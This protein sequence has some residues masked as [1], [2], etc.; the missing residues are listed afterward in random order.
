ERFVTDQLPLV[1][2][3]NSAE[4][5]E[6]YFKDK[7]SFTLEIP[8][9][10]PLKNA[11][12]AGARMCHLNK[13]PVAYLVYYIDNKPVSVFLMHEEEA[14]QFRQVR[15]EDLQIPENMKYHRVGDKLVMTCKAKKAILTALGQVDEP[16][17]HQL[18][19]AYE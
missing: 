6:Q 15:D 16:T 8:R 4:E 13:V 9:T 3:S 19:M 14:A 7:L 5:I 18:A 17:L 1:I 12:L 11:R 2:H 10:L